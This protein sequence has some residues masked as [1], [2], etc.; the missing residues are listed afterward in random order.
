MSTAAQS[1][2]FAALLAAALPLAACDTID[3]PIDPVSG[4]PMLWPEGQASEVG[5]KSSALLPVDGCGDV[6]ALLRSLLTAEMVATLQAYFA[7]ALSSHE[8]CSWWDTDLEA[9]A[10]QNSPAAAGQ[11]SQTESPAHSETNNQVEGVD[12]ADLVKTDG[13]YVYQVGNGAFRV[14]SS[15]PAAQ[16]K[17]VAKVAIEGTP[18]KLFVHGDRA[19][20]YSSLDGGAQSAP[21]YRGWNT[22]GECT[23][24][25]DCV[26][27]GDGHPTQI[28][29]FDL[30]DRTAPKL[31]RELK[32]SSSLLSARRVGS[33]VHTVVTFAPRRPTYSTWPGHLDVCD[34]SRVGIYEAFRALLLQNMEAIKSVKLDLTLPTLEDRVHTTDGVLVNASPLVGCGGFYRSSLADGAQMTSLVSLTIDDP[35]PARA[36]TI[37][38]RPGVVYASTDALYL[39]EPRV[40]SHWGWYSDLADTSEVTTVHKFDLKGGV[41]G[42]SYLASGLAKGRLLN[43]FS[44]DEH[45]G[46]LRLAS[47]GGHVSKGESSVQN[48]VTVLEQRGAALVVAGQVD[49]IAPGEDIRSVRFDGDRG[50]VVTFK[51]TDPLFVLD[52][53]SPRQ[54]RVLGELKIPGFSTYMHMMDDKHLLTIGYD[55]S[56]QGSFAWFTGVLLQIF[57]VSVPS[58]PTLKFKHLIGTR[59]SSS[60][61]LTDHLAFT[62]YAPKNLLALPMTI[63][64]GGNGDGGYGS[65]MTFSGLMVFD[66]TADQ[67]FALRGQVSFPAGEV[68]CGNWWANG[69]SA[70]KRSLVIEDFV[71]SLSDTLLKVNGLGNL[72][73]DLASVPLT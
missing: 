65:G 50:F 34:S 33:A 7:D 23:Y 4:A 45:D 1:R 19:L 41:N 26:P 11:T 38:S 13:S 53:A 18:K 36:V 59:G 6:D 14:L 21:G 51:K 71:Y 52:L 66:V 55:A 5:M 8:R 61:A 56:D 25:Y 28:S 44:L 57:D 9:M 42:T 63:C 37:V 24:G 64:E 62:Y 73:M 48:T 68:S 46:F 22:D 16:T 43:Q 40:R 70:V 35:L 31:V 10:P 27:T 15:W 47:T 32:L 49:G 20:V 58:A 17:L 54:P 2:F 29:I 69:S 30:K 67:G 72:G 60:E 12:E 3:A 39:A